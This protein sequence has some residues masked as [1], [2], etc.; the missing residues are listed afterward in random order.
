LI[1]FHQLHSFIYKLQR[2]VMQNKPGFYISRL[3]PLNVS[4]VISNLFQNSGNSEEETFKFAKIAS[5]LWYLKI[6]RL[7]TKEISLRHIYNS[8]N[9]PFHNLEGCL[10]CLKVKW[11]LIAKEPLSAL[12]ATLLILKSKKL[13]QFQEKSKA[14]LQTFILVSCLIRNLMDDHT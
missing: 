14:L 5:N 2:N 8:V 4:A 7:R 10:R 1:L 6:E 13:I 9:F 12:K 11:K 3:N